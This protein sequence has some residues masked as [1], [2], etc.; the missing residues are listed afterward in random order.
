MVLTLIVAAHH[1]PKLQCLVPT[2]ESAVRPSGANAKELTVPTCPSCFCAA[3][4]GRKVGKRPLRLK[5]HAR[6]MAARPRWAMSL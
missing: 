4:L 3:S 6:L 1:L 5:S 2:P